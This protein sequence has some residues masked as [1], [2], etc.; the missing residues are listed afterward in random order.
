MK[1]EDYEPFDRHGAMLAIKAL[2]MHM[3]RHEPAQEGR[4]LVVH[5]SADRATATALDRLN[6][7][8]PGALRAVSG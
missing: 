5:L 7:R 1:A 3:D 8:R 4:R 6:G 2:C